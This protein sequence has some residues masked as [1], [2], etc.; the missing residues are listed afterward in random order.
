MI[1]IEDMNLIHIF[2]YSSDS[3]DCSDSS[4]SDCSDS[5]CSDC[6]DSSCS[7]LEGSLGNGL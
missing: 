7:D 1:I 3:S 6:Y 2:N 5:S 4:C